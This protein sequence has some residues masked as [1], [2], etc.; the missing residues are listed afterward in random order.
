MGVGRGAVLARR[1]ELEVEVLDRGESDRVLDRREGVGVLRL[2]G[3]HG[4]GGRGRRART[5][6]YLLYLPIRPDL[7][8]NRND[9]NSAR[10]L[11][12]IEGRETHRRSWRER[13]GEA[14]SSVGAARAQR[15]ADGET[16]WEESRRGKEDGNKEEERPAN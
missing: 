16:R 5:G 14:V 10:T 2:V 3:G 13:D 1:R 9:P 12:T 11:G 8:D 4:G 7:V 15:K 6:V